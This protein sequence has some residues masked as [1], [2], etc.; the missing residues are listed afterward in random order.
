M[1]QILAQALLIAM[2]QDCATRPLGGRDQ[3]AAAGV[4]F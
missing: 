3:N 2:R 4:R 1:L